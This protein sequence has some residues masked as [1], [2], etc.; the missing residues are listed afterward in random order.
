MREMAK[1]WSLARAIATVRHLSSS[2]ATWQKLWA[3][4]SSA[5]RLCPNI[6]ESLLLDVNTLERIGGGGKFGSGGGRRQ[7]CGKKLSC[8]ED[9]RAHCAAASRFKSPTRCGGKCCGSTA[10]GSLITFLICPQGS[11]PSS[12]WCWHI[13][14]CFSKPCFCVFQSMWLSAFMWAVLTVG[15]TVMGP[16]V[17]QQMQAMTASLLEYAIPRRNHR[18]LGWIQ[19]TACWRHVLVKPSQCSMACSSSAWW[20]LWS[21]SM[22]SSAPSSVWINF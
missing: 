3:G 7:R 20:R 8:L 14:S 6:S 19:E 1:G 15:F 10:L 17:G 18:E 9:R 13:V 5:T 12:A 2:E 21:F 4:L 22:H 16:D 11:W